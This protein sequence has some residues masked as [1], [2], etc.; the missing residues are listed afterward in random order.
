MSTAVR[1]DTRPFLRLALLHARVQ[2]LET[3]RIPIAVIGN[4]F[5]P[6]IA[7]LFF[8]VPNSEVAGDPT[9]ATIAVAQL[10][11]FAVMSTALFTHGTGVA[12]DRALPFD[13]YQRTLPAAAAPRTAG[14]VGNGLVWTAAALVPVVLIGALFTE[15]S[16]PWW[17]FCLG[18]LVILALSVPFTLLGLAIGYSLPSKAALAVVQLTLFPL[19]F[20]GGLFLPP[21][22]FPGWLDAL[23]QGL[24]SRAGRD[25]LA[26]VLTGEPAGAAALPVLLGWT[27]LFAALTV[28]AYRRDEGR[29]FR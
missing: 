23:S 11:L 3:I 24:P 2:L 27:L 8:V 1:Q 28:W 26:Q 15:A 20:A 22:M 4:F 10:A 9:L 12:E 21:Q 14:R 16:L 5:F 18:F 7:L 17:R 19:A 25:L 6:A 13:A 29:R